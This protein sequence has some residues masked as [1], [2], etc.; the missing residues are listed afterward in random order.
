M[1]KIAHIAIS[2]SDLNASI[3]FYERH[4]GLKCTERLR[5][6]STKPEICMLEKD[7]VTLELFRFTN[8]DALPEY[9]KD[10]ES[11]GRPKNP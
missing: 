3:P 8:P 4:F 5:G 10:L 6:A 2:V 11:F 1:L 7:G 9:R